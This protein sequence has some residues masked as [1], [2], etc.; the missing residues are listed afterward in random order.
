MSTLPPIHLSI[1]QPAG[2]VHSLGLL[3]QAR[4]FRFQ[5]R[6]LGATVTMA[7]NRLQHG[8][9][10]IVF[11]AHLGFDAALRTRYTCLFVNLEQLGAGGA[12]V[13]PD[14]LKLL[15][16]SAVVDYDEANLASYSS[17]AEDTPLVP[18]LYAPYL[19]ADEL[20]PLEQRPI[21][22][23]FFGSMNP[24]RRAWLDRIEAL[25]L[26]VTTFDQPLYGA[27]RDHY[28]RQSKAVLN[29]HF[30]ESGRFEQARVS[31]CLSLGTPVISELTTQTQPH[32]SFEDAV[33][34]LQGAELEQFFSQD[35]GTAA[36]YEAAYAGLERFRAADSIEEYADLLAFAIG[37]HGKHQ[38]NVSDEPWRPKH[39]NLG[40][41]K[42]YQS[43]WLNLD[44]VERSEPDL[45]LDLS[46]PIEFPVTLQ[47]TTAGPV[48]LA[49]GSV[50]HINA[51][52]VLEHVADLPVLMTQCLNL[53][54]TGGEMCVEVPI[55]RAITAWQ[56]PTHVR[57]MN[58]NSWL[59]YTEWFWYLGWF[60]HRFEVTESSYLDLMLKPCVR[61]SAAFMRV[62]LKKVETTPHERTVART[63][64]A[65]LTIPNDTVLPEEY[66]F[67]AVPAGAS[68]SSHDVMDAPDSC[69]Q[70]ALVLDEPSVMKVPSAF[71]AAI[72]A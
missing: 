61:E 28:I 54:A 42:S 17:T 25:G 38:Q 72:A 41:G 27:E 3:D 13:S 39:I 6:R 45:L 44:V 67:A 36:W 10:N 63:M 47:S 29:A 56:D 60:E 32:A 68:A 30:Y 8:A 20:M 9:I 69:F 4:Y 31:H 64:Q 16:S 23:L 65:H 33:L 14:Y 12:T 15:K 24:R 52:N 49:E 1:V 70:Q 11:G 48:L 55:E 34:W 51:N 5:F 53:L 50:E 19:T 40:S 62:V 18:F 22:L 71:R 59:Y 43:G 57:A 66:Y 37:L 7:K 2:Y 58:E 35:W 21:D 26:E 46:Q